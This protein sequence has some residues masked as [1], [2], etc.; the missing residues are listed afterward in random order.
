MVRRIR[1]ESA[2]KFF[3]YENPLPPNMGNPLNLLNPWNLFDL[4]FSI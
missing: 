1:K 2:E 4:L 3:M